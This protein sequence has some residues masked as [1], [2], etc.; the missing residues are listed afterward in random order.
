MKR[1]KILLT[2]LTIAAS[3]VGQT[4]WAQN[5]TTGTCGAVGNE[6]NVI[7]T[8]TDTD[9]D[10]TYETLTISGTGAM[11]D[12]D[13]QS[14]D[15]IQTPWDTYKNNITTVVIENGVRSIGDCAFNGCTSLTIITIPNS[16]MYIGY[17]AFFG[18]TNVTDVY[19]FARPY[20]NYLTWYDYG[21]N[22]FITDPNDKNYPTKCHVLADELTTYQTNWSQD[23]DP[24]N[25]NVN[26]EF[27]GDLNDYVGPD[28]KWVLSD[29]NDDGIEE[30]LTISGT[31]TM[32]DFE[33]PAN[34][35]WAYLQSHNYITNIIIE[36]GVTTIGK[37]AFSGC[38][39]LK[40][41]TIPNSV[42]IIDNYAFQ[43]CI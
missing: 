22:D 42:T 21:C 10:N 15:P 20:Y 40:T 4:A 43:Y 11:A 25:N 30:T 36:D 32:W 24:N 28:I 27:V 17:D 6:D 16:V 5:P 19:C 33:S 7:W 2:L 18:C 23:P 12:Y 34:Q 29:E 35:P 9:D 26:V 8:V 38:H 13:D 39:E 37:N 41:V 3:M 14:G 1:K 31:G